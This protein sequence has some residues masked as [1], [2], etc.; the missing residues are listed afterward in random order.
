MHHTMSALI[1]VALLAAGSVAPAFA[2][3]AASDGGAAAKG[4][5]LFGSAGCGWCHSEGGRAPGKGPKLAGI[6]KDDAF[7]HNRIK[8]GYPGQMP[9]FKQFSDAQINS[10]IAYVRSLPA[11]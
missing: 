2:D 1:L 9:G 3:E 6:Q 10:L 4:E 11:Q 5:Q 7:I 8:N